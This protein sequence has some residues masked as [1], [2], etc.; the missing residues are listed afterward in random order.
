VSVFL[1]ACAALA[2]LSAFVCAGPARAVADGFALQPM[3]TESVFGS[4]VAVGNTLMEHDGTVN[5]ALRIGGSD[6]TID[7]SDMPADASVVRA[8]LFWAGT[9]ANVGGS[10][11]TVDFELPDGTFFNNLSVSTAVPGETLS[12][13]N[14]CVT[15]A[16]T[17]LGVPAPMFSCRRDVSFLLQQLGSGGAVGTYHVGRGGGAG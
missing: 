7:L 1:R 4:A 6:A 5:F 12:P 10:D 11:G 17:I 8:F 13:L 14:R 2:G 3:V 15:R 16:H 9:H